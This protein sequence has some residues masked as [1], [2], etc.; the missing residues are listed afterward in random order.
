MDGAKEVLALTNHLK[1]G[2]VLIALV[3]GGGS[4]LLTLP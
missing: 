4:S 3:S 1:Q 2:D